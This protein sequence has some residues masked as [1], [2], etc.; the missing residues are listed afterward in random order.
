MNPS[1]VVLLQE[2]SATSTNMSS[3]ELHLGEVQ[4]QADES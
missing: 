1:L 3:F 4:S 2:E